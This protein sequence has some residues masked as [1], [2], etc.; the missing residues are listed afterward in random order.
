MGHSEAVAEYRAV[1]QI[2]HMLY[3][4]GA[5]AIPSWLR[6]RAIVQAVVRDDTCTMRA[7]GSR[8]VLFEM[9]SSFLGM[10]PDDDCY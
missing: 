3:R 5:C 6:R 2:G 4:R 8:A 7:K 10:H 1:D 9:S